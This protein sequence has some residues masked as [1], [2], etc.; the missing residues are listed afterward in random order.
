MK[1][2]RYNQLWHSSVIFR[3]I[4]TKSVRISWPTHGP[5]AVLCSGSIETRV[6]R[7]I[8]SLTRPMWAFLFS[9]AAG[10]DALAPVFYLPLEPEN[11]LVARGIWHPD[12]RGLTMLRTTTAKCPERWAAV[13][14][15]LTI[16]GE[17]LSRLSRG[18]DAADRFVE[19]LKRKDFVSTEALPATQICGDKFMV[20]VRS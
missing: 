6:F 14:R 8:R 16:E 11:C 17:S 12:N 4:S 3:R 9:H 7:P 15:R 5:P 1:S 13:R 20:S 18:F 2:F 10:E 19:D